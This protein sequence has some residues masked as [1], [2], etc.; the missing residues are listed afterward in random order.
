MRIG[1][2]MMKS[3]DDDGVRNVSEVDPGVE[4]EIETRTEIGERIESQRRSGM[5][6]VRGG[7][8]RSV[9]TE[10]GTKGMWNDFINAHE[11]DH[12]AHHLPTAGNAKKPNHSPRTMLDA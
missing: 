5:K 7:R 8:R 1:M 2:K 10:S 12:G 4:I 11:I 9:E 6:T 3:G